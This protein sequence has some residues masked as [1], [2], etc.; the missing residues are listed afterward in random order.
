MTLRKIAIICMIGIIACICG[1][2]DNGDNYQYKLDQAIAD[3]DAEWEE[4]LA[5]RDVQLETRMQHEI[6][7]AI[8]NND[9]VWQLKL[10]QAISDRDA[11][12]EEVIAD[13]DTQWEDALHQAIENRD[14]QWEN[15]IRQSN[16]QQTLDFIMQI[17]P[18]LI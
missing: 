1:C 4:V 10:D 11:E 15:A 7:Y 12:W 13:R 6:D 17:L 18:L 5:D 3:R 14:A 8:S 9:V 16:D 2:L